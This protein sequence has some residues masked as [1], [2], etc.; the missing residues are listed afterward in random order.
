MKRLSSERNEW[1]KVIQLVQGRAKIQIKALKVLAFP[2]QQETSQSKVLVPFRSH[3][4]EI[5]WL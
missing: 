3:R 4:E 2:L 5:L 1:S